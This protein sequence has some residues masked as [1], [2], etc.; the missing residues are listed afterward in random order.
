MKIAVNA[1]NLQSAGGLTVALNFIKCIREGVAPGVELV[2]FAPRDRGYEDFASESIEIITIPKSWN[3]FSRRLYVD[4]SWL[5][6][7]IKKSGA[8]VVFTMGNF[9]VPTDL[10]Q[11]VLF[12]WPYAI[13]PDEPEVWSRMSTKDRWIRRLRIKAFKGRLK[14]AQIVF[15]QTE[16][17]QK[18]L[19]KYY[20]REIRKT[21]V[22]PMA[23]STIGAG[24]TKNKTFFPREAN[25]K[26]LLCLTRYYEHK[27]VEILLE[28]AQHIKAEQT[29]LRIVST[30]GADQHS[31][32]KAFIDNIKSQGLD[33]VLLNIGPVPIGDVPA[34]YDQVDG[35]IL[36]TLLESFSAT[37]VD[38]M[39]Y[40]KPIF[41][42][43]LDFARDACGD[44][45]IYFDPF[46]AEDIYQKLYTA[47]EQEALLQEKIA[48]GV[49]RVDILPNWESVAKA[50]V[51][52]LFQLS[53]A[54]ATVHS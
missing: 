30:I 46:S 32:A 51:D 10:P 50:Y 8:E 37:Y 52:Q 33:D 49:E 12:M 14:Y 16:T 26:Y 42:S 19:K 38:S 27:N 2:V 3:S 34:L 11:G 28:V 9:A 22:V 31:K 43:D 36:P 1:V 40:H 54:K 15:P 4:N 24:Q 18:R 20:P 35:L 45:G 17:S 7:Q 13:Y 47:F 48:L 29:P 44:C 5:P 41:T 23:F 25:H 39:R 6:R 53:G 21:A